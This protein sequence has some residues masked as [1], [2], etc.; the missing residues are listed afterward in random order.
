MT[1]EMLQ[2]DLI[3]ELQKILGKR[4]WMHADGTSGALNFYPQQLPIEESDDDAD[5]IP[6]VIV[7]LTKG[8]DPG[9]GEDNYICKA[10]VIIGVF[11]NNKN[12]Q[13]HRDVLSAI[14]LIYERFSKNT[15]LANK[16]TFLGNFDWNI[17]DGYHPYYFGAVSMDFAIPRI[18]REDNKFV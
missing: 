18:R 11:D 5:P 15:G 10:I 8:T 1:P 12:A 3:T 13:G 9:G 14:N 2:D 16:Y 4:K 6:Y 17:E 7:R